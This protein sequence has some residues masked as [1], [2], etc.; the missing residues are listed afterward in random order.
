MS[1]LL[2]IRIPIFL[3]QIKI[4]YVGFTA[5]ESIYESDN[6][7]TAILRETGKIGWISEKEPQKIF[8]NHVDVTSNLD[9]DDTMYIVELPEAPA[10]AVLTVIE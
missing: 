5:V 1:C 4:Y 2:T 3:I 7:V 10:R 9:R 8:V 6:N